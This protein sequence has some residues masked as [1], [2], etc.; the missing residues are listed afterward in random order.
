MTL[1]SRPVHERTISDPTPHQLLYE[2]WPS[3]ASRWSGMSFS[4]AISVPDDGQL[5]T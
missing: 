5:S 1:T 2:K 4:S 3:D